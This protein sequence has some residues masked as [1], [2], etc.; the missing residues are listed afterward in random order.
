MFEN[1]LNLQNARLNVLEQ[2]QVRQSI[3][4][5]I[6]KYEVIGDLKSQRLYALIQEREKSSDTGVEEE[7]PIEKKSKG[8]GSNGA[9]KKPA[10]LK[11][12]VPG[13]VQKKNHILLLSFVKESNMNLVSYISIINKKRPLKYLTIYKD[14]KNAIYIIKCSFKTNS[15]IQF[16]SEEEKLAFYP[17]YVRKDSDLFIKSPHYFR[18][19]LIEPVKYLDYSFDFV[20]DDNYIEIASPLPISN[21]SLP[22]SNPSSYNDHFVNTYLFYRDQSN[23]ILDFL[24]Y[25]LDNKL[26]GEMLQK[27]FND[28]VSNE[29]KSRVQ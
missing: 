13:R 27:I 1:L 24:A 16:F 18:N 29:K 15:N 28:L 26:H 2:T 7:L 17:D 12:K 25:I 11:K 20:P 21:D 14:K 8:F 22:V 10:T 9:R 5:N 19:K 23:N 6:M 3:F 4:Y